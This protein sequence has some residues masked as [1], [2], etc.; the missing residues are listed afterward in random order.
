[1]EKQDRPQIKVFVTKT[2][3]FRAKI[4]NFR[5]ATPYEVTIGGKSWMEGCGREHEKQIKKKCE[6]IIAKLNIKLIHFSY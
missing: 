2:L 1:M 6:L 4:K 5:T 3:E